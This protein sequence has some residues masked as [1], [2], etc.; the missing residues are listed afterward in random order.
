[1]KQAFDIVGFWCHERSSL[2]AP[3]G[4]SNTVGHDISCPENYQSRVLSCRMALGGKSVPP[5]DIKV[6]M[7]LEAVDPLKPGLISVATVAKVL[8]YGYMMISFH[9]SEEDDGPPVLDK[10]TKNTTDEAGHGN[11]WF[12]YHVSSPSI[13]YCGFANEH[14]IPLTVPK[15]FKGKSFK[16]EDYLKQT[17]AVALNL[18]VAH[19]VRKFFRFAYLELVF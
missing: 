14:G 18:K 19:K 10:I 11:D 17:G 13:F 15:E 12:C 8:Q 7:K 9:T 2:V 5:I 1:M 4:W 3:R 16:W 6:G